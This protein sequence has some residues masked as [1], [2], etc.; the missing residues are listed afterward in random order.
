VE[1]GSLVTVTIFTSAEGAEVG[2]TFG[3]N[4][5]VQ[6][7]DNARSGTVVYR[8]LKKDVAAFA[9]GR[10][11]GVAANVCARCRCS[12]GRAVVGGGRTVASA[13]GGRG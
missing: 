1:A 7:E 9:G 13:S 5:I 8:Q 4:V 6:L 11:C 12:W 3:R 10:V 2:S